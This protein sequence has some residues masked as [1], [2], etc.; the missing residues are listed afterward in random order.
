M[1]ES[2]PARKRFKPSVAT[3]IG[4][5][6]NACASAVTQAPRERFRAFNGDELV[7]GDIQ[8]HPPILPRA[9]ARRAR[10]MVNRRN[11]R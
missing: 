1:P 7:S 5:A 4:T 9:D 3:S 6:R 11:P 2:V 10:P 8:D